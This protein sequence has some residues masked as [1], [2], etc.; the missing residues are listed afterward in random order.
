MVSDVEKYLRADG[1]RVGGLGGYVAR[2]ATAADLALEAE[3]RKKVEAS[4]AAIQADYDKRR[5]L[6]QLFPAELMPSLSSGL[7]GNGTY[8]LSFRNLTEDQIK[9][10]AALLKRKGNS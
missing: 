2:I 7:A 5:E 6:E 10:L 8:E 4:N 3:Q 1:S 9:E